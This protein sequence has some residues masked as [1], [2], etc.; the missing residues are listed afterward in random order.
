MRVAEALAEVALQRAFG[1]TYDSIDT[2][3]MQ[4][5]VSDRTFDT[6]VPRA[7]N[8]TEWGGRVVLGVVWIAMA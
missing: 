3:N 8:K 6:S 7:I 5:S 4:S 1:F 2:R